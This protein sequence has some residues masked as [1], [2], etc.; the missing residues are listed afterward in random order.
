MGLAPVAPRVALRVALAIA[1]TIALATTLSGC[2]TKLPASP[3]QMR[4][5]VTSADR[6]E[7]GVVSLRIVWDPSLGTQL[8]FD[9]AQVTANDKTRIFTTTTG[10]VGD[11]TATTSDAL[12]VRDVVE[13]WIT[14]PVLESY[15]V[16]ATA[17]DIVI[18]GSWPANRAL[19]EP[20]GFKL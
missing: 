9:A 5:V 10:R 2:G 19:P 15:P 16:Q 11:A 4:G 3:P 8:D 20:L 7:G 6:G 12:K 18:T 17:S 14:G 1:L 13:V